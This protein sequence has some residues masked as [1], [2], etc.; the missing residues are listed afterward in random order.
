MADNLN[1]P[2]LLRAFPL[3]A[4]TFGPSGG[5]SFPEEGMSLRDWFA[6]RVAPRALELAFHNS[7]GPEPSPCPAAARFAYEMADALLAARKTGEGLG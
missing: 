5:M 1:P 4:T 3:P 6:G 7:L 2:E